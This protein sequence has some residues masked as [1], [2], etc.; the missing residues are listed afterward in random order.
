MHLYSQFDK[1]VIPTFL[2]AATTQSFLH[3]VTLSLQRP[4]TV[5]RWEIHLVEQ[6]VFFCMCQT[7]SCYFSGE[8]KLR[9]ETDL[10]TV[11]LAKKLQTSIWPYWC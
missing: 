11:P 7:L 2:S 3:D 10:K 4:G 1:Y 5:F 9:A 6:R 8:M